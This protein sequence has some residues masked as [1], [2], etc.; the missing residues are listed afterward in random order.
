MSEFSNIVLVSCAQ[1]SAEHGWTFAILANREGQ[2]ERDTLTT[3]RVRWHM[4]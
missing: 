3:M 2:R 4:F 1:A